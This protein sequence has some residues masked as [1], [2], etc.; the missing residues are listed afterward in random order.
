MKMIS[1]C[2]KKGGV[3]KTTLCK[4]VAYKFALENKKVLVID[5][6]TQATISFLMQ[7]ENIDMSKS[8]HKIIASDCGMNINKV[9]QPTK[10]KN[11]DIIVGGETLK[12]SLIVMRELYDNDNFYLIGIK[13]YQSNQETFDGYDYVLIDYPPTTDDLSLNWL[14]FSDLIVIPTNN[15]SGSYKGILDLNN[16]LDLILNKL[17]MFKPQLKILFNDITETE[18]KNKFEK[19]LKEINLYDNLLTIFIKHSENFTTSENDFNSIWENP[20][21]WRQKQAYEELI[22]EIK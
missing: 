21:Y 1:F 4:N 10:Y 5:L 14:I 13:I 8:L 16:N 6:D 15:G 3:G 17:K 9:I 22:K 12:K 7:N 2:N 11:I 18:N 20:Y 19:W